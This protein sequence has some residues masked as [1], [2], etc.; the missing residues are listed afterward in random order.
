MK[1]RVDV[2]LKPGVLD[3]QGKAVEGALQGMGHNGVDN[4]R[5]GRFITLDMDAAD[6]TQAEAKVK[7]MCD[8][9]L[10]NPVIENYKI[11]PQEA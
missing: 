5:I 8:Q 3:V 4:V 11:T 10:A 9:L 7:E 6:A 2:S 1:F